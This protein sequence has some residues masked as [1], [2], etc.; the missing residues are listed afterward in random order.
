MAPFLNLTFTTE[1]DNIQYGATLPGEGTLGLEDGQLSYE[2]PIDR[3]V[4]RDILNPTVV[5]AKLAVNCS[6]PDNQPTAVIDGTEYVVS[7][8]GTSS[9]RCEV[10]SDAITIQ[11]RIRI[12]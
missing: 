3:V 8:V 4:D 12:G 5:D 10:S 2:G 7:M 1:E 6:Q 9:S 11:V